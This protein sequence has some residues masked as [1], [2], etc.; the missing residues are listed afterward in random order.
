MTGGP[1]LTVYVP[2]YQRADFLRECLTALVDQGLG[3]DEYVVMVADNASSDGTPDVVEAFRDRLQLD[4]RRN[5]A[6]VPAL[7]NFNLAGERVATRWVSFL[8]DDDLIPPGQLG[9]AMACLRA[10]PEAVAYGAL[11]I[12]QSRFGDP[13]AWPLGMLLDP[14]PVEGQPFLFRW[15]PLAWLANC[16]IQTP[17]TIIGSVFD[18]ERI[19]E[20]PIFPFAQEG[21]RDLFVRLADRGEI[22][23]S[24]WVGGHLRYHGGQQSWERSPD[25]SREVTERALAK[26]RGLG[27]DLRGFW[28]ERLARASDHELEVLCVR[29][30][31]RWDR[32]EAKAMLAEAGVD[33]RWQEARRKRRAGRYK[34]GLGSRLLNLFGGSKDGT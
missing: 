4:H 20:R 26:A 6:T 32:G 33:R 1:D 8:C 7:E 19:P 21:D 3:R 34:P 28:V 29:L 14:E 25:E 18:L 17:L 24:A 27:L 9:R 15:S 16:S 23:T 22:Y 30:L 13:T 11:G 10:R 2:T 12:G 5:E 31:K